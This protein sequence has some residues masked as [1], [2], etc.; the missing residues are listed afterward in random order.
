MNL[1]ELEYRFYHLSNV[2]SDLSELNKL[3]NRSS[4]LL[5]YNISLNQSKIIDNTFLE[6]V[7]KEKNI[8]L[9]D[10][11]KS[12]RSKLDLDFSEEFL[13][14]LCMVYKEYQPVA[15]KMIDFKK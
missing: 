14:E 3:N 13:K 2:V 4:F 11:G 15:I 8:S 7:K 12:L 5:K 10:F 1:D 6:I 9:D